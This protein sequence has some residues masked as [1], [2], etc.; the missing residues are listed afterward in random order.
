MHLFKTFRAIVVFFLFLFPFSSALSAENIIINEI[1]WMGTES[2]YN[3]EWI[4]LYNPSPESVNLEEWVL[5]IGEKENPLGGSIPPNSFYIL[6]RTDDTTLPNIPADLIYKGAL[7]NSGEAIS[8]Y[9]K[10]GD[11]VDEADCSEEWKGGNNRTKQTMEKARDSWQTSKEPGGTPDSSNSSGVKDKILPGEITQENKE[12]PEGIIF[13]EIM[14]SPEGPDKE[15]EWIKLYNQN[16]FEVNLTNWE[17]KD[18]KGSTDHY[19][20]EATIPPNGSLLLSRPETGITLNNSG[21]ALDLIS[22]NGEIIDSVS[23]EKAP[24]GEIFAREENEWF[25]SSGAIPKA[26]NADRPSD[27]ED[28]SPTGEASLREIIDSEGDNF[29]VILIALTLAIVCA[30][31]ILILKFSLSEKE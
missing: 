23:Y 28:K 5:K 16:N 12:Y 31:L 22:P 29:P 6:E 30:V 18:K 17:I 7:K 25:W 26:E 11:L 8:L 1:A 20:I 14:P 4:E 10:S 24:E 15:E 19:V 2:S 13:K 21:D 9:N 27:R 3:D